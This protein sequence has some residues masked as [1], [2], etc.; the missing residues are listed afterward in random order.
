MQS[1]PELV[2]FVQPPSALSMSYGSEIEVHHS[3]FKQLK[4]LPDAELQ[5]LL[6]TI[7][8]AEAAIEEE[9][10]AARR[11]LPDSESQVLGF[12]IYGDGGTHYFFRGV[13]HNYG[14]EPRP[15]LKP[16]ARTSSPAP[17]SASS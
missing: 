15:D 10:K 14:I 5:R 2:R 3:V 17:S 6:G 12:E 11:K 1:A 9:F 13:L 8:P 7:L 16:R 4:L